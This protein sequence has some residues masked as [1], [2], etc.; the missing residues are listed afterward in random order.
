MKKSIFTFFSALVL[1]VFT[2]QAF[3][4]VPQGFNYQ[5]VARNSSGTLLQNQSLG[6]KLSV[7]QGSAAGAV[8]Y[9]E[10]QTP[11]TNQFGL[12]TVTVGQGTVLSGV[13]SSV[14][15]SSG[16]YWLQV[17]LD[18]T[19][20]TTYTD[21]GTSQLLSVPYAMYA[22]NAGTS[23][24]TGPTGPAGPVGATGA[25]GAQGPQGP[26]GPLVAGTS[27]QTLRHNGTT[28]VANSLL[29]NDGSNV[30]INTGSP[31]SKLHV[32][33]DASNY[34]EIGNASYALKATSGTNYT[35]LALGPFAAIFNGNVVPN[36]SNSFDLGSSSYGFRD[37]YLTNKLYVGGVATANSVL[38]TDASGVLTYQSPQSL[39]GS[40]ANAVS[41]DALCVQPTVISTYTWA[42]PKVTLVITSSSQKVLLNSNII[43]GCGATAGTGMRL[44]GGYA[45]T[46]GAT[47][48]LAGSGSWGLTCAANSRQAYSNTV[49]ITGL[50]PGTYDFGP[51]VYVP[52][53]GIWTNNEVGNC[54]AILINY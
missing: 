35:Y 14:T 38:K 3:A 27:G 22:A 1:L 43:Y 52:T 25:T 51:V 2:S 34:T 42:G 17:E 48:T 18:V 32:Y 53:L 40:I 39:P 49:V 13:F 28:W 21:M 8:V 54:S 11:T 12:F 30:G 6:V 29:Y 5:A 41:I 4:Q 24:A 37:F 50:T 9:S 31:T 15:W 19:G 46:G 44:Y 10:R 33:Y 7:H 47:P 45:L 26:T 23:G 16:N 36:L 20:G